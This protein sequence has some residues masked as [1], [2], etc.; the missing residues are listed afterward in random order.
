MDT[1]KSMLKIVVSLALDYVRWTQLFPMIVAW[2]LGVGLLLMIVVTH[3]EEAVGEKYESIAQWIIEKPVVAEMLSS[4]MKYVFSEEVV[5]KTFFEA[6][7]E[8]VLRVWA[9]ISMGMMVVAWLAR[10]LFGPFKSWTL[11]RKLQVTLFNCLLLVAGYVSYYFAY[12]DEFNGSMMK[13]MLQFEIL[14]IAI[15]FASVWSLVIS[16][17]LGMVQQYIIFYQ[18]EQSG[19]PN[20]NQG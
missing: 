19:T 17:L 7:K 12:A 6:F 1:F 18:P 5:K 11:T 3:N 2:L 15:F 8:V 20:A 10:W 14:G 16:H 13:W 4:T 9:L